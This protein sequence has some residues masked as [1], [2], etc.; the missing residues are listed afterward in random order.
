MGILDKSSA[1]LRHI[2]RQF[3]DSVGLDR[4]DLVF[5]WLNRLVVPLKESGCELEPV[6]IEFAD[7][8]MAECS[9][10]FILDIVLH[11]LFLTLRIFFVVDVVAWLSF[12][13]FRRLHFLFDRLMC[14]FN[15]FIDQ[16]FGVDA[17]DDHEAILMIEFQMLLSDELV[18]KWEM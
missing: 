17:F 18:G 15:G 3:I 14:S 9:V 5:C 12:L 1:P 6:E 7:D 8:F 16:F 10:G 4:F 11:P 13:F 2:F